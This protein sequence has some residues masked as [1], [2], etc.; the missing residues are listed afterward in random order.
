MRR[1]TLCRNAREYRDNPNAYFFD[2]GDTC[3]S[4][5]VKDPRF[6]FRELASR[7]EGRQDLIDAGIDDYCDF[8]AKH[9]DPSKELGKIEVWNNDDLF[10]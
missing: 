6:D 2:L 3:N 7:F 5:H 1:K 8:H 10:M 4:I 9:G